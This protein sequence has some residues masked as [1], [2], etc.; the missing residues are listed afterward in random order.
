ME[1]HI[2]VAKSF[3]ERGEYEAASKELEKA[4][5]IDPNNRQILAEIER[6]QRA[7]NAEKALGTAGIRC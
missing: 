4:S 7:C 5:A 6:T 3:R 2:R 1:Y